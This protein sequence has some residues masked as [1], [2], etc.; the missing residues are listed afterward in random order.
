MLL[1]L[2]PPHYAKDFMEKLQR[3]CITKQ[4]QMKERLKLSIAG[5]SL[6]HDIYLFLF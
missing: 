1:R 2:A 3:S 5:N 6:T 4:K